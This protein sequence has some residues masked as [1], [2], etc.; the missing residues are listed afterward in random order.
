MVLRRQNVNATQIRR[1]NYYGEL[2]RREA[3]SNTRK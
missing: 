1:E 3:D 2:R